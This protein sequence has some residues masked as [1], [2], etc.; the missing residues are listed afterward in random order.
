[1]KI[2]RLIKRSVAI[3]M[4]VITTIGTIPINTVVYAKNFGTNSSVSTFKGIKIYAQGSGPSYSIESVVFAITPY[5][6]GDDSNE[7]ILNSYIIGENKGTAYTKN[8]LIYTTNVEKSGSMG[9]TLK[10][11]TEKTHKDKDGKTVY[12]GIFLSKHNNSYIPQFGNSLKVLKES[13][14][15]TKLGNVSVTIGGY[16][17]TT[18]PID[19]E[20]K[21]MLIDTLY[22][23]YKYSFSPEQQYWALAGSS[24][25][26][27]QPLQ[28]SSLMFVSGELIEQRPA[29]YV[30]YVS[31]Q[32]DGMKGKY[33]HM[34]FDSDTSNIIYG[35]GEETDKIA[36]KYTVTGAEKVGGSK[37]FMKDINLG[38]NT[39]IL[40]AEIN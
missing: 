37:K 27:T 14:D 32:N 23:E 39:L 9:Y 22:P 4:I 28:K 30:W 1:M 13:G 17:V 26:N 5:S 19:K 18:Y 29:E 8:D 35:K 20:D 3:F 10:K 12:P 34:G 38:R 16:D 25:F 40:T 21:I 36:R 24:L 15:N 11:L 6:L 2:K 33:I 31:N 7:N